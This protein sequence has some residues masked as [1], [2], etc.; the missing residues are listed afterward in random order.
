MPVVDS[1]VYGM[2]IH[3]LMPMMVILAYVASVKNGIDSVAPSRPMARS[4]TFTGPLALK[5]VLMLSRVTNWGTAMDSTNTKRQKPL[6]R[7]SLRLM[8]RASSIP[9]I[10]LLKVA[11]TAQIR[12]QPSTGQ[13]VAARRLPLENS[14]AKLARPTHSN[15][16]PGGWWSRS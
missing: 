6:M 16:F 14:W 7:V 4:I 9:R 1:M 2:P 12:V 13:K 11:H 15:R 3:I 10:K 5:M 8:S